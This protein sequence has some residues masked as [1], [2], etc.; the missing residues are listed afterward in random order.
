MGGD[1][2]TDRPCPGHR[3][4]AALPPGAT[5]CPGCAARTR[6]RLRAVPELLRELDTTITRQGSRG[7]GTGTSTCPA[8][9]RHTPEEA[10]CK[11]PVRLDFDPVASQ[12]AMALRLCIHGW[13]RIWDEQT[14]CWTQLRAG[15]DRLLSSTEGQAALLTIA[16]LGSREWAAECAEEIR[17]AT[18]QGWRAI[19]R[20]PDLSFVGVC[21]CGR[22]LMSQQGQATVTCRSCGQAWD[23]A[24][25]RA[26]MLD[27]V[28][29]MADL[30]LTK[31]EL[32]ILA[33]LPVGTLHRWSS[34]KRIVSVGVNPKGQPL[35]RAGPVLDATLHGTPPELPRRTVGPAV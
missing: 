1:P 11:V 24:A 31:P 20:P 17:E 23:T 15:R 28:P 2:L 12:A 29:G 27:A 14:P 16:N 35:Y 7:D 33:G 22:Q 21:I 25:S 30:Q 13:V 32:A 19:D 9:C 5:I 8:G 18:E 34:E 10:K 6:G 26:W 4:D 3:C